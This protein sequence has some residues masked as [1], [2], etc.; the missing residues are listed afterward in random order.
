MNDEVMRLRVLVVED[1]AL[2]G[3]EIESAVEALGHEVVGPIA[4]LKSALDIADDETLGCAILDVNI[5]GGYSYPVADLLLMRGVPVLFLSGYGTQTFPEKL[6]EEARLAK[7][8]TCEQLDQE[9]HK[10][11]SRA[12]TFRKTP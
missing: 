8:F 2:I 1:E 3:M 9:I 10:L 5:R 11:C 12:L 7:P 4:E 6:R